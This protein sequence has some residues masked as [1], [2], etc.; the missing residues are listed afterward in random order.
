MT[1]LGVFDFQDDGLATAH[2]VGIYRVA[3]QSLMGWTTVPE[4]MIAPLLDGYRYAP[5]IPFFLLPG[6]YVIVMRMPNSSPDAQRILAS[7]VTTAPEITWAGSAF[8]VNSSLAY[9][10]LDGTTFNQGMFGPNFLFSPEPATVPE[11]A[12]SLLT[13]AGALYVALRRL[14]E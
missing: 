13:A 14:R 4:G 2:D 3:D 10:T 7:S 11:P 12:T 6:S 5:V 8:S 1:H 9:P